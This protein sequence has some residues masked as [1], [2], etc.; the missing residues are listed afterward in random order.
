[1]QVEKLSQ[2]LVIQLDETQHLGEREALARQCLTT[3][4]GIV[5]V[6]TQT[7]TH[8][9]TNARTHAHTHAHKQSHLHTQL[10]KAREIASE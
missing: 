6:R 9:H 10:H 4:V 3:E 1:M 2:Q 7:H 5:N 8:T